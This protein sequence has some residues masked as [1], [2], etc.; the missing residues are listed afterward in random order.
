MNPN[1]EF[2][3]GFTVACVLSQVFLAITIDPGNQTLFTIGFTLQR[4]FS[5][6]CGSCDIVLCSKL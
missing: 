5:S 6:I 2:L 3:G 4:L 1:G